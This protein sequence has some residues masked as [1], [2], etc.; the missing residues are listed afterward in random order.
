MR[1]AFA[2]AGHHEPA[3][4]PAWESD[5]INDNYTNDNDNKWLVLL[6]LLLLSDKYPI[7]HE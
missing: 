4:G 7:G 6:S 3:D 5:A 2:V 1:Q